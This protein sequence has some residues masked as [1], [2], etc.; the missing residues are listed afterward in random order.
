MTQNT[1]L[2]CKHDF[3]QGILKG[4]SGLFLTPVLT[5]WGGGHIDRHMRRRVIVPL[6]LAPSIGAIYAY[7]HYRVIHRAI[8]YMRA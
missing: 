8:T 5:L 4:E 3:T 6:D 7:Y 2:F 1:S